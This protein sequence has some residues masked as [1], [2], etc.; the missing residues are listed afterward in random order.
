MSRARND[1]PGLRQASSLMLLRLL[2]PVVFEPLVLFADDP[3]A[4]EALVLELL[5]QDVLP[6]V[7]L[8]VL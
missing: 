6:T 7:V 8:L 3:A 2:L 1:R 5:V 4:F